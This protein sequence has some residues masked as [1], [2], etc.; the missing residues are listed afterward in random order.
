MTQRHLSISETNNVKF[1]II[2]R[3]C[4]FFLLWVC[5]RYLLLYLL[6]PHKTIS[7]TVHMRVFGQLVAIYFM[8]CND[9]TVS[10]ESGKYNLNFHKYTCMTLRTVSKFWGT[11]KYL[12]CRAEEH[13]YI[14]YKSTTFSVK[15]LPVQH[16]S[17]P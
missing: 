15:I 9:I 11:R 3:F 5:V 16:L 17:S 13:M 7:I 2:S 14:C 12:S 8:P 4:H 1:I 10:V 6:K